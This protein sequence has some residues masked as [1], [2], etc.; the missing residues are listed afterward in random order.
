MSKF[1]TYLTL[2]QL[3]EYGVP[4]S[5]NHIYVLRK[6]GRFPPPLKFGSGTRSRMFW[7]EQDIIDWYNGKWCQ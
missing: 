4:Y 7:R 5:R 1:E 3:P 6:Q 2:E